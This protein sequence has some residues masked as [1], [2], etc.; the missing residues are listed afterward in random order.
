MGNPS[1]IGTLSNGDG[2]IIQFTV[3]PTE[4][5]EILSGAIEDNTDIAKAYVDNK[6]ALAWDYTSK[7]WRQLSDLIASLNRIDFQPQEWTKILVD[8]NALPNLPDAYGQRPDIHGLLD[9][10]TTAINNVHFPD[11]P[12]LTPPPEVYFASEADPLKSLVLSK[13]NALVTDGGTGLGA[14]VE[15]AIW[16]RM[17]DRQATENARQWSETEQYFAARGFDL[18]PGALS[19]RLNEISADIAKNN[20]NINNDITVEQARLAQTNTHFYLTESIKSA[21][22]V[23]QEEGARYVA[24]N[25]YRHQEYIAR[26]EAY[27]AELS[28]YVAIID[29][30]VKSIQAEADIYKA[31]ITLS[32]L[33]T[34]STY[35]IADLR[36]R[37]SIADAEISLK[38]MEGSIEQT[39]NNLALEIESIKAGVGV[40]GQICASALTSVSASTSFGMSTSIGESL[41][42]GVSNTRSEQ[43]SKSED[44]VV[45]AKWT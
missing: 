17:R 25:Q 39:K 42:L 1:G 22:D 28:G 24:Y 31:D 36:L 5:I 16:D 37:A 2:D 20:T 11:Y 8:A 10:Y 7:A 44:L 29:A 6:F 41:N 45:N 38:Q 12:T 18:P 34:E 19:G 23:L 32:G 15:E 43:Q 4:N 3:D 13:L 21:V 35:K 27:K 40:L 30:I 26:V 33:A 14:D 9:Q